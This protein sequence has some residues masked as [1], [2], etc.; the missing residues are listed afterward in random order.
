MSA[1]DDTLILLTEAKLVP[2]SPGMWKTLA[3]VSR[4]NFNPKLANVS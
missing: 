4:D 1:S 3:K 2:F